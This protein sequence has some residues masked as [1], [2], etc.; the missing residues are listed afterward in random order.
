MQKKVSA[1]STGSVRAS[2]SKS[3]FYKVRVPS[4]LMIRGQDYGNVVMIWMDLSWRMRHFYLHLIATGCLKNSN[5]SFSLFCSKFWL[6]L[7]FIPITCSFHAGKIRF[8]FVFTDLSCSVLRGAVCS[9]RLATLYGHPAF[10]QSADW[11]V[12]EPVNLKKKKGGGHAC[13]AK[14]KRNEKQHMPF[15]TRD[16]ESGTTAFAQVEAPLATAGDGWRCQPWNE[17]FQRRV[18][19]TTMCPHTPARL[20]IS[21]ALNLSVDIW[22]MP[23]MKF[24]PHI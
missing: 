2:S 6:W 12:M 16:S 23:T 7:Q 3:A 14:W 10:E 19:S 21:V 20:R 11:R 8:S 17:P 24:N 4:L 15:H 13:Y 9:A 22:F 18:T 5:R 1:G